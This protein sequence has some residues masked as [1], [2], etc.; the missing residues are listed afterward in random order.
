MIKSMTKKTASKIK[1]DTDK[2]HWLFACKHVETNYTKGPAYLAIYDPDG[3]NGM[4]GDSA[5]ASA[6]AL[7]RNPK[8][9]GYVK[10]IEKDALAAAQVTPESVIARYAK[11]ATFDAS[12]VFGWENEEIFKKNGEPYDP[13][14]YKPY[15]LSK[16]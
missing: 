5:S 11:W 9:Q 8:I 3:S 10:K 14:R 6:I 16:I 12:E 7:L 13:K 1:S 4:S 2:R 15:V